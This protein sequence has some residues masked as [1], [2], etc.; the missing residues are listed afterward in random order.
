MSLL[1]VTASGADPLDIQRALDQ[2]RDKHEQAHQ[3]DDTTVT[4]WGPL[5]ASDIHPREHDGWMFME[6]GHPGG[7]SDF[8]KYAPQQGLTTY[9]HGITRHPL[10]LD[11]NG[12]AW[13]RQWNHDL[14]AN[15][16]HHVGSATDYLTKPLHHSVR[17]NGDTSHYDKLHA[18]GAEP[19]TAYNEDYMRE[20]NKRLRD[21]G[22]D[23]IS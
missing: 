12:H 15:S 21:N 11:P 10:H 23:V 8:Y 9:K 7:S 5:H 4:N 18:M 3:D 22:F 16:W 6:N 19:D 13:Q 17:P 1:W 20:R 2:A 14:K